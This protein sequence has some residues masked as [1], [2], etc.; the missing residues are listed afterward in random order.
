M[1]HHSTQPN[2]QE[3]NSSQPSSTSPF[4]R[5]G[6]GTV[7]WQRHYAYLAQL[8][9]EGARLASAVP[10]VTQHGKDVGRWLAATQRRDFSRLN[11]EQQARLA[12]LGVTPARAARARQA[13]AKTTAFPGPAGSRRPST[14]ASRP[15]LST[16]PAKA[17]ER[18]A[19]G[20]LSGSQTGANIPQVCGWRTSGSDAT[21]SPPNS[22][23]RW[24]HSDGSGPARARAVGPGVALIGV[25]TTQGASPPATLETDGAWP[26]Q[27]G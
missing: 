22:G 14:R 13:P 19:E 2:S 9:A 25:N 7:D 17:A 20:P 26:T 1:F 16:S 12:T 23:S 11:P 8:L 24:P 21:G 18:R 4:G 15:S 3:V 5:P 27:K 10:G 6:L